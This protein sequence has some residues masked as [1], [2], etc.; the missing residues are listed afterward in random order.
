MA[1]SYLPISSYVRL[2]QLRRLKELRASKDS[3]STE[4]R[5]AADHVFNSSSLDVLRRQAIE[6][7]VAAGYLNEEIYMV[8]ADPDAPYSILIEGLENVHDTIRAVIRKIRAERRK[9][10]QAQSRDEH[11]QRLHRLVDATW[12]TFDDVGTAHHKGLLDFIDQCGRAIAEAEGIRYTRAGR[13]S[14][15]QPEE[16]EAQSEDKKD[17]SAHSKETVPGWEEDFE[18]DDSDEGGDIE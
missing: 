5:A 10:G 15:K 1:K 14:T 18:A 7:M 8:L 11:V 17:S 12:V 3:L 9:K 13:G 16:P 6:E 2:T 4:Q